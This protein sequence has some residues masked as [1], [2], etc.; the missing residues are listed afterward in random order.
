MNQRAAPK[1]AAPYPLCA[2]AH[3]ITKT[4]L[5]EE[6]R[7]EFVVVRYRL[8][9]E[10]QG[11]VASARANEVARDDAALVNELVKTVLAVRTRFTKVYFSCVKWE[12]NPIHRDP[13]A[14]AFHVDLLNVRWKAQQRL[15]IR[16]QGTGTVAKK[17]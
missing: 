4:Y 6:I 1:T 13:L 17:G 9:V 14:I 7:H 16:Q 15:R 12:R 11:E 10:V 3:T 5:R 2:H 8:S